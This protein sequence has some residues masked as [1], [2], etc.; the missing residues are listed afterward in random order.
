MSFIKQVISQYQVD[1]NII[2]VELT[3]TAIFRDKLAVLDSL[4]Q[5]EDYHISIHLDD[6]GTGYSSLSYLNSFPISAIKID[7]SFVSRIPDSHREERLVKA[8]ILMARELKIMV[9]AEGVEQVE[10]IDYLRDKGCDYAQG[11][12]FNKALPNSEATEILRQLYPLK[13]PMD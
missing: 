7:K 13:N 3:E 5:L 1:A 4:T 10:Q 8:L 9:I 2:A 6:F 11:Y 12:Y